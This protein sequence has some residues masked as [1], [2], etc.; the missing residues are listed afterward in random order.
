MESQFGKIET[1]AMIEKR[2]MKEKIHSLNPKLNNKNV[3]DPI[4]IFID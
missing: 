2:R 4:D 1:P 3:T